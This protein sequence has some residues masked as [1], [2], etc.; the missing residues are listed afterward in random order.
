IPIIEPVKPTSTLVK[1]IDLFLQKERDLAFIHNPQVGSYEIELLSLKETE[2]KN[3]LL[4]ITKEEFILPMHIMNKDSLIDIKKITDLGT[5]KEDMIVLINNSDD[6]QL[7]TEIWKESMPRFILISD[8]SEF[9]RAFSKNKVLCADHFPKEERNADY[10]SHVDRPFSTDHLF[11]SKENYEGFS[12]FSIVGN[13]FSESG[14]APY[15]VIIHIV[16]FDSDN[17]LR[18]RHFGSDSNDDFYDPAGK[19]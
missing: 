1:T 19:F 15:A 5:N 13:H 17:K 18:I 7:F 16:Y 11:F 2:L 10:L 6:L 14:F 9:R 4:N 12:D 3:K 8:N